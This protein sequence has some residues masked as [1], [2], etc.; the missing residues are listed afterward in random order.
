[1]A[2][3]ALQ[4]K[5]CHGSEPSED[6]LHR[7]KPDEDEESEEEQCPGKEESFCHGIGGRLGL[8]LLVTTQRCPSSGQRLA[9]PGSFGSGQLHCRRQLDQL[10]DVEFDTDRSQCRPRG[11]SSI[12]R[13]QQG[14][15]HSTSGPIGR[16]LG[17]SKER[18][19][20]THP[21]GKAE[22]HQVDEGPD[23]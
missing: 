2:A 5:R 23:Q 13:L 6:P 3:R 22:H 11:N 21:T 7:R 18:S 16:H 1:M 8:G 9:D 20:D 10:R 4:I 19:I 17:S 15:G 14:V 12:A